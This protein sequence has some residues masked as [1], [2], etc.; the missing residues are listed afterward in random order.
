M[1]CS[2]PLSPPAG[3]RSCKSSTSVCPGTGASK[4]LFAWALNA[5]GLQLPQDVGMQIGPSVNTKSLVIQIHYG[6]PESMFT[7]KFVVTI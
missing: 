4:I 5:S 7:L 2:V 3:P 1:Y 6:H